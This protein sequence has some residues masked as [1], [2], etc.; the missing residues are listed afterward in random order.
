MTLRL[1]NM[2]R[3][4]AA[5]LAAESETPEI[6]SLSRPAVVLFPIGL[7]VNS[8]GEVISNAFRVGRSYR[9]SLVVFSCLSSAS[10]GKSSGFRGRSL[11][12]LVSPPA[13]SQLRQK[14]V[15]LCL[16]VEM[17]QLLSIW[18]RYNALSS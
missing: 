17:N 4:L 16:H 8:L 3:R 14:L 5:I 15:G 6:M 2:N 11:A 10:I 1:I 7:F 13:F 9:L 18:F 12:I